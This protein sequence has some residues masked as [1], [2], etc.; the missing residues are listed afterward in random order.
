MNDE[1]VCD[2]T[3]DLDEL[4]L[5]THK[6][7]RIKKRRRISCRTSSPITFNLDSPQS[8]NSSMDSGLPLSDQNDDL[9]GSFTEL[10]EKRTTKRKRS[11]DDIP[12][13]PVINFDSAEDSADEC[14]RVVKKGPRPQKFHKNYDEEPLKAKKKPL[15]CEKNHEED[16]LQAMTN[17]IDSSHSEK[18][19]IGDFSR[20]YSLPVVECSR[21]LRYISVKTLN[22]LLHAQNDWQIDSYRI[23][24]CRYPYEFKGGHVKNAEN[25]PNQTILAADLFTKLPDPSKKHILIFHCEFS[26]QRAPEMARFVR[27]T[28]RKMNQENFPH[29]YYPEIYVIEGGYKAIY[30][31]KPDSCSPKAYLPMLAEGY[32]RELLKWR[33]SKSMQDRTQTRSRAKVF[34]RSKSSTSL[35]KVKANLHSLFE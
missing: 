5:K 29:L 21:D 13:V 22:E 12:V 6:I 23:I 25:F 4:C 16:R 17:I 33:K 15:D 8:K 1:N 26:S 11:E 3:L 24:D 30:E 27:Q 34:S 31:A 2:L 35:G 14:F 28:D 7:D 20:P 10:C 9:D 32:S 18:N 19:L